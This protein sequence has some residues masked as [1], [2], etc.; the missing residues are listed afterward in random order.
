MS[1]IPTTAA[2]STTA[3]TFAANPL[4][5]ICFAGGSFS[6]QTQPGTE[7]ADYFY[8]VGRNFAYWKS[9]GFQGIRIAF[10]WKRFQNNL[11]GEL[12]VAEM[13]R[14]HQMMRLAQQNGLWVIF[15]SHDYLRY[16]IANPGGADYTWGVGGANVSY[17]SFR[18]FWRRMA[19]EFKGHPALWGYELTNEPHGQANDYNMLLAYQAAISGIREAGDT[20]SKIFL[21]GDSYATARYWNLQTANTQLLKLVDPAGNDKL[22]FCAHVYAD[23]DGSGAYVNSYTADS[24][25]A[26]TLQ[27]R[28]ATFVTWLGANSW[29]NG[30]TAPLKGFISEFGVPNDDPLYLP[31]LYNFITYC[32]GLGMGWC[33]FAGGF[34]YEGN[35]RFG[36][37]P[38]RPATPVVDRTLMAPMSRAI[39]N[40][41]VI[42]LTGP[43]TGAR[44]AASGAFV[45]RVMGYLAAS[46][47]VALTDSNGGGTFNPAT[48]TFA[49][50]YN[51]ATQTATYTPNATA[52]QRLVSA[53]ASGAVASNAVAYLV[54]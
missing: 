50:G 1:Y 46:K 29:A 33:P 49:A 22:V 32:E 45:V 2:A 34:G 42:T 9:K 12:N 53:T 6:P 37:E 16:G 15:D 52:T 44:S 13:A 41:P 51:P 14:V 24:T 4:R 3:S 43:A 17:D 48:L 38:I 18:D 20:T 26:T 30:S 39:G 40:L 11:N 54:T 31:L 28:V 25:T 23:A 47:A 27:D 5:W 10:M 19:G 8:S 7:G 35:D 36:F 21:D